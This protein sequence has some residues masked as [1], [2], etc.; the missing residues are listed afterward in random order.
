MER[1]HGV[2]AGTVCRD[3]VESHVKRLPELESLG[4]YMGREKLGNGEAR[5]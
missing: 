3:S 1:P 2:T 4:D 5:N